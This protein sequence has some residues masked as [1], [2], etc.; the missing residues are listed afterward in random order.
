MKI[1]KFTKKQ[2]EAII[3][4]RNYWIDRT[5]R[6]EKTDEEIKQGVKK[7]YKM[8]GLM[9]P[10]VLIMDSPL[11][12]QILANLAK[13][14]IG[15]NIWQNIHQNIQQ[16]IWQNI[17]ENIEQNIRGNIQQNIRQNIG[18]NIWQN[19]HQNIEQNIWQNI[20]ENIG[21]NIRENIWGKEYFIFSSNDS[22]WIQWYVYQLFYF[23]N[24]L[25]KKDKNYELLKEYIDSV[26]DSWMCLFFEKIAIVSRKP[27]IRR[28]D[29][30]RLNSH[31]LAAVEFNDGF[32]LY[33]L[34]G[35]MFTEELWKK[36]ISREMPM[37]E[38]LK[39]ADI[40]K[41]TQAMKFA[42][43]GLREFYKSQKGKCIDT[44]DKLNINAQPVH[45]ELWEIPQGEIFNQ[46]V[47]FAIYDCPTSLNRGEKRE[48]TKGTPVGLNTVADSMAWGMSDENNTMT[49]EMW[50]LLV[51]LRDES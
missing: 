34:N 20:R 35:V 19:I 36:I 21:E 46:T 45:Y 1:E 50:K 31:H 5:L 30:G 7:L 17:G 42:K 3:P 40:D 43:S 33:A 15:E 11:G 2:E 8:C 14:N 29:N 27:Q 41:R 22:S 16:N 28:N 38:V 12:T 47:H 4:F 49:A 39:I 13:Q 9:E 44:Y 10:V 32:K 18:E 26:I 6:T 51:P 48:Y 23:E 37:E 24:E 25:L